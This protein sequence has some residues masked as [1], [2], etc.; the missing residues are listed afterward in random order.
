M[1]ATDMCPGQVQMI[2]QKI[3]KIYPWQNM[4]VNALA[5]DSK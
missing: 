3:G 5:I 2:A 4:R 1:L